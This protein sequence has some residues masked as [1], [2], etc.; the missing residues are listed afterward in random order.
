MFLYSIDPCR[1]GRPTRIDVD[2]SSLLLVALAFAS[3]PSGSGRFLHREPRLPA[4]GQGRELLVTSETFPNMAW[5]EV[6]P[7]YIIYIYT[8]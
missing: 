3:I 1:L 2:M 6:D 7:Q 8:P 5:W 4:P